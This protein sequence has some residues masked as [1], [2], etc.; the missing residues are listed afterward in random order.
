M[1]HPWASSSTASPCRTGTNPESIAFAI[2]DKS[3]D[4][5]F[6]SEVNHP[7]ENGEIPTE[8]IPSARKGE[9]LLRVMCPTSRNRAEMNC[10][11]EE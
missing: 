5:I 11:L 3:A 8:G 2:A 7:Q 6:F 10:I 4:A 1:V 9:T